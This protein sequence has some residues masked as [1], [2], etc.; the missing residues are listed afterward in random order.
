MTRLCAHFTAPFTENNQRAK[1]KTVECQQER[2]C[3]RLGVFEVRLGT[4]ASEH[5]V[6]VEVDGDVFFKMK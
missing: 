4:D 2:L 1:T 3:F 6:V 5:F